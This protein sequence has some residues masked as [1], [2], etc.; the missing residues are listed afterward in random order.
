MIGFLMILGRRMMYS[1]KPTMGCG[2]YNLHI[3]IG[4]KSKEAKYV[5]S[6]V[7]K[8]YL[9]AVPISMI[10]A[11]ETNNKSLFSLKIPYSIII[12]AC[13][14]PIN[15]LYFIVGTKNNK[16]KEIIEKVIDYE[17]RSRKDK[18]LVAQ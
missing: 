8:H 15:D 11:S 12:D 2:V 5:V 13:K 18:K 17:K 1:F 10:S 14:M 6:E 4:K 7:T 9:R 16:L 3:K